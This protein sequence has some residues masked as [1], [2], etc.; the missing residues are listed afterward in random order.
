MKHSVVPLLLIVIFILPACGRSP[1]ATATDLPILPVS[2]VQTEPSS[3]HDFLWSTWEG[4][5]SADRSSVELVPSRNGAWPNHYNVLQWLEYGPCY[6]CVKIV[7]KQI[8]D[9]NRVNL[10]IQIQH[11]F[12]S[13]IW[14][15]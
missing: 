13:E 6:D 9:A 11:P 7:D 8:I 15:L 4:V 1:V 12:P 14:Y 10:T 3:G 2:Q 5:I